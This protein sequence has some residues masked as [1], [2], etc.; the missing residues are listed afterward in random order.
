[1]VDCLN[2]GAEIDMTGRKPGEFVI[3]YECGQE[4]KVVGSRPNLG[5]EFPSPEDQPLQDRED[6]EDEWEI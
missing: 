3:C 1:M 5:I 4:W 6:D 2:C